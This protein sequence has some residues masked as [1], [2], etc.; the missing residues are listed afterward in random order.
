[1]KSRL[2]TAPVSLLATALGVSMAIAIA[3]LIVD[4]KLVH[5]N[6]MLHTVIDNQ[7]M[8]QAP[9]EGTYMKPLKGLDRSG[10]ESV[11]D[12]N[13]FHSPVLLI[14][15]S[16]FCHFCQDEISTWK[17]LIHSPSSARVV[18]VNM[19]ETDDGTFLAPANPSSAV[20]DIRVS[21]PEA[22]KHGLS[23]TPT[24]LVVNPEGRI[25]WSWPGRLD[26]EQTSTVHR[27]LKA[28]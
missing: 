12:L 18:F 24:T 10:R 11:I 14:A 3:T 26:T 19:S 27:L 4:F 23:V 28:L 16:P 2:G 21:R 1:M 13:A 22:L 20:V 8:A 17:E 9:P 7:A 6:R 5:E 25:V 15:M